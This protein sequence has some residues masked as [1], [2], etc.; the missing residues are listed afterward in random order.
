MENDDLTINN[1]MF[2]K[3][4][5]DGRGERLYN[6]CTIILRNSLVIDP[7]MASSFS[8]ASLVSLKISKNDI[9]KLIQ[10]SEKDITVNFDDLIGFSAIVFRFGFWAALMACKYAEFDIDAIE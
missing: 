6:I 9:D 5:H 2:T 7:I 4:Q 8:A 10:S 3:A 1:D